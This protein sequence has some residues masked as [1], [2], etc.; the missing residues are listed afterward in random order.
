MKKHIALT[1]FMGSGKTTLG[2]IIA[3]QSQHPFID[4]DEYIEKQ[5]QKTIDDIFK[6]F[7]EYH[8]RLLEKKHIEIIF[9]KQEQN[10]VALGG[11][12]VCFFDNLHYIKKN[13]WLI[14][15]MPPTDLLLER[16]W[17]EKNNRPLIKN[18]KEKNELKKFIEDKLNERMPYYL[19]ADWVLENY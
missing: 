6:E 11:G 14:V 5:E 13:A 7:G 16:L 8:F 12:T 15:L 19:Q 1:G 10:I 17:K 9:Q 2:K 4:L 18:I 3:E